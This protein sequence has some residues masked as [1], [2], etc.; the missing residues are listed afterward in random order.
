M[1]A[2]H[3]VLSLVGIVCGL[4]VFV[5]LAGGRD[6]RVMTHVFFLTTFLTDVTGFFL[7][8]AGFNDP[9]TIVGL[10]SLVFVLLAASAY[11]VFRTAG[12]WRWAYVVGAGF[13]FYLN[14][15]VGVVQAFQKI[16]GLHA[17]A[18]AGSEPPFVVAQASVVLLCAV[19]GILALRRFRPAPQPRTA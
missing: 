8:K 5:A 9:P 4:I 3:V 17:I 14:A 18:P 10:I 19:L 2:I 11:Y 13:G 6:L 16:P 1:L 7:P 15:F 12:L